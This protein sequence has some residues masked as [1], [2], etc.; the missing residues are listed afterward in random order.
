MARE[1][2]FSESTFVFPAEAGQTRKVRIFTPATEVPFAG[3]PNVGTAFALATA[4]EFGAI[5]E[6]VTVTFEEKAGLVPVAIH[7]REGRIWCELSAPQ[8]LSLGKVVPA[9][10]V[11]AAVSLHPDHV[12]T[13][14]HPPRVASV[15]LP[16]LMAELKDRSALERARV[17]MNGIDAIAAEGVMPDIHLY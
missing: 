6:P 5:E 9:E 7:R 1:F 10:M 2:N 3:H 8:R 17:N 12:V 4:G 14:T 11:A 13:K 16:F 15:G